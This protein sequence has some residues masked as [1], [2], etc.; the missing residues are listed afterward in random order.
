MESLSHSIMYMKQRVK[1]WYLFNNLSTKPADT[2]RANDDSETNT[3]Q[4]DQ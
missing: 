3:Y 4:A 1:P 2:N